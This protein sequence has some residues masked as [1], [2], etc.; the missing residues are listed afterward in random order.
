MLEG[1]D[2]S[3]WQG[4]INFDALAPSVDFIIAKATEGIGYK[5]DQFDRNRSG[6]HRTGKVFGAYHFARPDL[7]DPEGEANYFLDTVS[8]TPDEFIS[9]DFEKN[10]SDAAGWTARFSAKI[11]ARTNAW[12]LLYS[13]RALMAQIYASDPSDGKWLADPDDSPDGV[14]HYPAGQ[15]VPYFYTMQ[16]YGTIEKPG[17]QGAVDHDLFFGSRDQLIKYTIGGQQPVSDPAPAPQPPS[18]PPDPSPAPDPPF[19]PLPEP[20]PP[21][22]QVPPAPAP[23]VTPAPPDPAPTQPSGAS[24]GTALD[25]IITTGGGDGVPSVFGPITLPP[26]GTQQQS[27]TSRLLRRLLSFLLLVIS[28]GVKKK[29]VNK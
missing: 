28:F 20:V 18:P 1:V 26:D 8:P 29:P 12:P 21:T 7:D 23:P 6:A 17:I 15:V 2:V 25:G 4:I 11:H 16:Q 19:N 10:T 3:T 5:D 9:L 13:P 14:A 24:G 22:P 27:S